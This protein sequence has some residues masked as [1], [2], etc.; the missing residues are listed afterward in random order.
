MLV[1]SG[2]D[3]SVLTD[4]RLFQLVAT[5]LETHAE[6]IFVYAKDGRMLIAELRKR[7]RTTTPP[8]KQ[9]IAG[10]DA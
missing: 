2:I 1:V 10:G 5:V 3:P 9:D 6:S 8:T 4:G 7:A